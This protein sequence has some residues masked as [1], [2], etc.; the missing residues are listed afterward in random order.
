MGPKLFESLP[1]P[2]H[3]LG[4]AII[5]NSYVFY[6]IQVYVVLTHE[7]G[8]TVGNVIFHLQGSASNHTT[9]LGVLMASTSCGRSSVLAKRHACSPTT[10]VYMHSTKQ[11]LY[12]RLCAD[13]QFFLASSIDLLSRA[14][15]QGKIENIIWDV[16]TF[17]CSELKTKKRCTDYICSRERSAVPYVILH[18][19]KEKKCQQVAFDCSCAMCTLTYMNKPTLW[20]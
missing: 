14:G 17:F 11:A 9:I 2:A 8:F 3:E 12:C 6:F 7:E 5:E 1:T 16:Q 19:K 20:E 10:W 4:N 13:Q 15:P 18:T